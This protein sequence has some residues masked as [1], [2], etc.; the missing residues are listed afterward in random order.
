MVYI[1]HDDDL[2]GFG[3]GAVAHRSYGDDATYFPQSSRYELPEEIANA[4]PEDTV[5]LLDN[6]PNGAISIEELIEHPADVLIIDHHESDARTYRELA[7]IGENVHHFLD[8]TFDGLEYFYHEDRSAA[9]LAWIYFYGEPA[10]PLLKHVQDYDLW[11][12]GMDGTDEITEALRAEGLSYEL[13]RHHLRNPSLLEARGEAIVKAR[14]QIL[15]Q[16][17]SRAT[18]RECRLAGRE[19]TLAV[20]N[21]ASP[22]WHSKLGEKVLEMYPEADVAYMFE[23]SELKTGDS[24]TA[25]VSMRSRRGGTNVG[26]IARKVGGGGHF[27]AAGYEVLVNQVAKKGCVPSPFW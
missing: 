21:N 23:L 8:E 7:G 27:C 26:E 15:E 1:L 16:V 10:P 12:F 9:V 13:Y 11:R 5:V 20:V 4:G 3:A 24:T 18:V 2:D 6:V 22:V 14:E 19:L 17:A 25:K